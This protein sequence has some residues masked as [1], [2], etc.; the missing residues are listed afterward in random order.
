VEGGDRVVVAPTGG[1]CQLGP[2]GERVGDATPLLELVLSPRGARRAIPVLGAVAA[3]GV[4]VVAA[5][6]LSAP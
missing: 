1:H 5:R 2:L 6:E 3:A 4:A